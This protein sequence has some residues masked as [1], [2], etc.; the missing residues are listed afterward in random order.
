MRRTL[1]IPALLCFAAAPAA[2]QPEIQPGQTV[3]AEL[4]AADPAFDDSVRYDV[5]RFRTEPEHM[6]RVVMRSEDFDA[7]LAV[8]PRVDGAWACDCETDDDGAGGTNAELHFTPGATETYEIRANALQPHRTGRYTLTLEDEG[9]L[10]PAD[11][12]A[13]PGVVLLG[14][15]VRGRL[16]R[17]DEKERD[18]SYLDTYT[19]HGRRGETLVIT[20]RSTDFDAFLRVGQVHPSGCRPVPGNEADNDGGGGTDS[21]VRVQLP[22]DGDFHV[23]VGSR[24][25]GETG[26][27]TLTVV[28]G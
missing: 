18:G 7:F 2:A 23:H 20:L 16:E 21:R 8:G 6:Y 1:F 3:T 10:P 27:Y 15:P 19:Y 9:V 25:A 22:E 13:A 17:P 28:R 24:E 5:W 12:V 26:A 4:T 14:V 11:T